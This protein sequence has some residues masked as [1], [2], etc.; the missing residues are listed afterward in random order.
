MIDLVGHLACAS[1]LTGSLLVA[2]RRRLGWLIRALGDFTWVLIGWE[3]GLSS[4]WLWESLSVMMDAY[5]WW[6]WRG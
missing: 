3:L 2:K 5:G 4:V 6:R 1:V